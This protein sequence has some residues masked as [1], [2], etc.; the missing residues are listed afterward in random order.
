MGT[1]PDVSFVISC[2][3]AGNHVPRRYASVFAGRSAVLSTHEGYDLGVR[4]IARG[5]AA[6]LKTP[7]W[8]QRL[9]RLLIDCNRSEHHPS[10]FSRFSKD[11]PQELQQEL[12]STYREHR[13]HVSSAVEEG[14]QRGATVVHVA[15]HSFTPSLHGEVRNADIGLLYDP[16]RSGEKQLAQAWLPLLAGTGEAPRVRRNYPYR[17]RADG[18]TTAL[19]RLYPS[20]YVAFEVEFNQALLASNPA[21]WVA[22]LHGTLTAA[23]KTVFPAG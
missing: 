17:G 22:P 7:C 16:Q 19:R 23:C 14:M 20:R 11:L 1:S 8:E 6:R 2:E 5:L 4:A 21:R 9:T 18:L 12:L 3:H 10:L 13:G 15:V